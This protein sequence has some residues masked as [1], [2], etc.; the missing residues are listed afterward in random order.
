MAKIIKEYGYTWANVEAIEDNDSR[1]KYGE[2]KE[3]SCS[4]EHGF[5]TS[6]MGSSCIKDFKISDNLLSA[7]LQALEETV[8]K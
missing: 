6:H 7:F 4:L 3:H 2:N 8:Q 1:Y 5:Y